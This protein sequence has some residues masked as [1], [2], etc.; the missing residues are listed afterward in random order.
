MK[1]FPKKRLLVYLLSKFAIPRCPKSP[2]APVDRKFVESYIFLVH[3]KNLD[4]KNYFLMEKS[5]NE[6]DKTEKKSKNSQI[7]RNFFK[8]S[9]V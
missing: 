7:S 2:N 1:R 8:V 3:K 5:E 9:Y 4:E 6:N